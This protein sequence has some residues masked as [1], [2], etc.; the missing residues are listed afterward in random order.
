MAAGLPIS[1][2]LDAG[3]H[4]RRAASAGEIFARD[5]ATTR[6]QIARE[7]GNQYLWVDGTDRAVYGLRHRRARQRRRRYSRR[8]SRDGEVIGLRGAVRAATG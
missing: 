3:L 2:L 8:C 4:G 7:L 5:R 1:L 6:T